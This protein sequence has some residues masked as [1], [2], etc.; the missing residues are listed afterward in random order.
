MYWAV[1]NNHHFKCTNLCRLQI[2]KAQAVVRPNIA[3][4][5]AF[6]TKLYYLLQRNL[7]YADARLDFVSH[8]STLQAGISISMC[9]LYVYT[10]D[11]NNINIL[12]KKEKGWME[13]WCGGV[14]FLSRRWLTKIRNRQRSI[15]EEEIMAIFYAGLGLQMNKTKHRE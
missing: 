12:L 14:T 13:T 10:R 8:Q 6:K 7:I 1:E 9:L 4:A 2:C 5:F 15:M 3:P 11:K